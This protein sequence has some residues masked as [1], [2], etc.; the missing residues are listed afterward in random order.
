MAKKRLNKKVALIGSAVVVLISLVA[1]GAILHLSGDPE[2]FSKDGDAALM[3]ARNATDEEIK[4]EAYKRAERNYHKARNHAKTDSQRI[5]ILFKLVDLYI[6]TK[7]W[8]FVLGNWSRIISIDPNNVEARFGQLNYVY[9]VADSGEH[10]LWQEVE[11]QATK[12]IEDANK[13]KADIL[14]QDIDKLYPKGMRERETRRTAGQN[15][16]TYLYLRRGRANL[17]LTNLGAVTEPEETLAQATDDFKKV[18][19]LEPNNVD[20]YWY[21][22]EAVKTQ[23]QILA[24]KGNIGEREK[25]AEKAMEILRQAVKAAP[26]NP[27]AHINLLTE[28]LTQ[29]SNAAEPQKQI[30]LLEDEYMTLVKRFPSCAE[31]FSAL[32]QYYQYNL[33]NLDQAIEAVRKAAELDKNNVNYPIYHADMLYRK[34]T[35]Y[36]DTQDLYTA[37]EVAKNALTLPDAQEETGPRERT[38]RN[39]RALLNI[40]LATYY[41][42]QVLEPSDNKIQAQ[43]QQWL[44]NA[45]QAVHEIEQLVGSG[46]DLRVIKWRGMIELAKGNQDSAIRKLYTVYEQLKTLRPP[47]YTWPRDPQFAQLSYILAKIFYN[48]DEI[49]A[50]ADFLTSALRSGISWIKPESRLDYADVLLKLDLWTA[51]S[52]NINVFEQNF[53]ANARSQRLR[54]NALLGAGQF[55]EAEKELA[56][57]IA[58]YPEDPNTTKLNLALL[59]AKIRQVQKVINQRKRAEESSLTSQEPQTPEKDKDLSE[60]SIQSMTDELKRYWSACAPLV[61][62]LLPIEPDNAMLLIYKQM[63]SEPQPYNIPQQK[64]TEI[65]ER[66][67]S[68]I[69][70][71]IKRAI[72]LGIFYIRHNEL[73]KATVDLKKVFSSED[74]HSKYRSGKTGFAVETS[75]YEIVTGYLFDIA[76]T[77]KDWQLAEQIIETAK[78]ENLDGCDGLFFEAHLAMA[79]EQYQDALTKINESLKQRPVFSKA[80][81]LRSMVNSAL[82]YEHASIEDARRASALNPRD[83]TI[84]KVLANALYQRDNKLGQNVSSEQI[85]ETKSA[86]NM[87]LRT[88]PGDLEILSFYAEYIS[89]EEPLRALAIRQNLQKVSPSLQNAMLLARLAM[90]MALRETNAKRKEALLAITDSSFEQAQ[91]IAPGNRAVTQARAE[92]YRRTGQEERAKQLVLQDSNLLWSHYFRTGRI[93]EARKILEQLYKEQ[94]KDINVIK[95]LLLVGERQADQEAV[96]K[97]SEELISLEDTVENHLVQIQTFL[98]TGLVREADLKLQSFKEKHPQESHALLLEAWLAMKRGQLQ[99]ALQLTTQNLGSNPDNAVAWRLRGQN[100]LLMANYG[101]AISDLKQ[102]KSLSD[103][104]LTRISLA[105]AYRYSG[106]YEDAITELTTTINMPGASM[107]GRILLEQIYLQ[108]DRK[109]SL[110]KFYDDTLRELPD[111][112]LWHNRIGEFETAEGNFDRARNLYQQAWQKSRENGKANATAFDGY[113]RALVLGAG[114]PNTNTWNTAK[115]DKVFEEGRQYVDSDFAHIAYF[116][117]AEAKMKLDDRATAVQYCRKAMDKAR[118]SEILM[119]Q[120][121]QRMHTLLG[122]DE[123]LAYCRE[124][125]EANPGSLA[126]NYTMFNFTKNN[127]EYNKAVGYVD[128]CLQIIGPDSPK[129]TDYIMQK[130]ET[131]ILAYNKTSDNNYLKKAVAEYES[132]LVE[133]PNNISVLN[134]LAYMLAKSDKR[135]NDALQ[136]AERSLQERPNNPALLDTY[137]YVLHKNGKNA[138]ADESL[139][140]ALQQYE[141]RLIQIP[142]EVY[143]HLGMVKEKLNAKAEALAAYKEALQIGAGKLP[144]AAEQ[145]IKSAIERLSQ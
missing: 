14:R 17:E 16:G 2:K 102:S 46:E 5:E 61:E 31:A 85:V 37:I 84:A 51:A 28:K 118:T 111:N 95:G 73:E 25:A 109:D 67:L 134:N 55:D 7:E 79:K 86:L 103:D 90:K 128:K 132:L 35:V 127:G 57:V 108:L 92:F 97:Y 65:E 101:Q 106:L 117:M 26:G 3:A 10:Q 43:K 120:T 48:T 96:M 18:Q 126:A 47:G 144:K 29:S 64:L 12:F 104:P 143:E 145:Q 76:L 41:T 87:A 19:E 40:F 78:R 21:L 89:D 4:E 60:S 116:R 140:A 27:T 24:S 70:D 119:A 137:A 112:I 33:K 121:L 11:E 100:H 125:L 130:A 131:L 52:D 80:L 107:E 15:L 56:K 142:Y 138:E 74:V 36:G 94:S 23:G 8:R 59:Q 58:A 6:E 62:K 81:I 99:K 1:I 129:R 139:Q 136:Y 13:I 63:I 32:S 50:V 9:I 42:E 49:G 39:N 54:V 98:K 44:K 105:K 72:S 123:A 77:T 133:M 71:P 115:L 83:G 68:N 141:S 75:Q 38:N 113:L 69:S 93:D 45:E 53:G 114:T 82:G 22:A 88:N 91:A 110:K 20:A 34:F 66:A 135:L 30:Q 124:N 122:A